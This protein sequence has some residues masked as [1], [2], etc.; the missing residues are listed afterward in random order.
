MISQMRNAKFNVS[1]LLKDLPPDQLCVEIGTWIGESAVLFA[2]HYK[3]V[4]CVDL[5]EM[6]PEQVE[7]DLK[8]W[9]CTRSELKE[10]YLKRIQPYD[11]IAYI[12]TSSLAA[13]ELFPTGSID[14]IYLD[15][16]HSYEAVLADIKAWLPKLKV[17]R[18]F[19]GHDYQPGFEGCMRA[20]NKCFCRPDKVYSDN[21][22]SV[23]I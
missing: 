15:A 16:D 7:H 12:Q 19:C 13:A 8:T 17:G 20:V 6:S 23:R 4:V 2:A 5:W 18:Y 1:E 11:N 14:M 3:Q 22:W 10:E 21:S 9:N